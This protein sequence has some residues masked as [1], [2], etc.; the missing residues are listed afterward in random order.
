VKRQTPLSSIKRR[1]QINEY[2]NSA[3]IRIVKFQKSFTDAGIVRS[4]WSSLLAKLA[5]ARAKAMSGS[6]SQ[7]KE[8]RAKFLDPWKGTDADMP[9]L[10]QARAEAAKFH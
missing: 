8:S 6:A 7:A 5:A 10:K 9:T 1:G 4:S 2:R 3:A